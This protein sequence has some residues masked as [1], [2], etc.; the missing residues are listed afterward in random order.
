MVAAV[1]RNLE[2]GVFRDS[3]FRV[4]SIEASATLNTRSSGSIH[5]A[6]VFLVLSKIQRCI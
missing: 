2:M 5:C 3:W 1:V 6:F 4:A